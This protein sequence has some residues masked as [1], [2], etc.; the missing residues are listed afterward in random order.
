MQTWRNLLRPQWLNADIL[1]RR[2]STEWENNRLGNGEKLN[3]KETLWLVYIIYHSYAITSCTR[4]YKSHV[5]RQC[6]SKTYFFIFELNVTHNRGRGFLS[7]QDDRC[8]EPLHSCWDTYHH[9]HTEYRHTDLALRKTAQQWTFMY[10]RYLPVRRQ[11]V[12]YILPEYSYL[13]LF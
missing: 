8:T 6:L 7:S 11:L 4:G 13:A 12:K 1:Q 2:R 9:W 3:R 5:T 10:T